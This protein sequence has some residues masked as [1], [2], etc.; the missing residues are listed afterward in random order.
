M[1]ALALVVC[2]AAC[3]AGAKPEPA[4]K[5]PEPNKPA[6]R[7]PEKQPAATGFNLRF[8]P[9]DSDVIVHVDVAKLRKSKLWPTYTNDARNLIAPGFAGCT[10][11]PLTQASTVDIG[12]PITSQLTTFVL[13]GIDREQAMGCFRS[14]NGNNPVK[15]TFDGDYITWTSTQ[16]VR[17][18]TFVDDHTLVVQSSKAPTKQTLKS[19][20]DA[21]T[22]LA[23]SNEL[24]VVMGRA[25]T[26]AAITA[27]SRPGSEAV[28]KSMAQ[29]GVKLSFFYGS[30]DLGDQL[31]LLYAMDLGTTD[32]A[33]QTVKMMK[34]QMDAPAVKQMFDRFETTSQDKTVSLEVVLGETKLASLAGMFRGMLTAN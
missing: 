30:I 7:I 10:Y 8:L 5:A 33:A 1:R 18:G 27:I 34:A 12:V 22:P 28:S 4:A 29:T 25:K 14:L 2:L 21:G 23:Q 9:A 13:R 15:A 17:V 24:A 3:D 16:A 19:A 20:I 26:S 6:V 31:T 11:D 32:E